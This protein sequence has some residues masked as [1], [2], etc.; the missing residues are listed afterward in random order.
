MDYS[1][2]FQRSRN[3]TS[4]LST[5]D[6]IKANTCAYIIPPERI[7][8]ITVAVHVPEGQSAAYVVETTCSKVDNFGSNLEGAYWD[9][10]FGE[11]VFENQN[12]V[13]M[14]ANAVTAIRVRCLE[15]SSTINVCFVG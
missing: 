3:G 13:L 8:A 2:V 1:R 5:D 10:P 7:S 15:A 11:Q 14:I 6:N 12:C 4:G 9:N